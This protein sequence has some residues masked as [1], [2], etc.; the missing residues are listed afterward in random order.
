MPKKPPQ[1]NSRVM[2][3]WV[4]FV[5]GCIKLPKQPPQ[6]LRNP[7]YATGPAILKLKGNGT[8]FFAM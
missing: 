6:S 3:M 2:K 7:G 4:K 5:H 1:S 8:T